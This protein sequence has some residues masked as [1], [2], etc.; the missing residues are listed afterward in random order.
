[1]ELLILGASSI[2]GYNYLSKDIIKKYESTETTHGNTLEKNKLYD[3]VTKIDNT[4]VLG[5]RGRHIS[6]PTRN[7]N[8]GTYKKRQTKTPVFLNPMPKQ[9]EPIYSGLKMTKEQGIEYSSKVTNNF[10]PQE[11][12]PVPG[13]IPLRYRNNQIDLNKLKT[14]QSLE[15]VQRNKMPLKNN[16]NGFF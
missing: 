10:S 1:M 3:H 12:T 2:L 6:A 14:G 8:F 4:K 9:N 13:R 7:I 15:T 5:Q 16:N 11:V